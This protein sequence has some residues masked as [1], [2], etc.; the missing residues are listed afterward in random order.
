[1]E[2]WSNGVVGNDGCSIRE[3]A[4]RV[5]VRVTMVSWSCRLSCAGLSPWA[6]LWWIEPKG[7]C[8]VWA[9][10]PLNGRGPVQD[11]CA[12]DKPARQMST[13]VALRLFWVGFILRSRLLHRD[14]LQWVSSDRKMKRCEAA[15]PSYGL[16]AMRLTA[17]VPGTR[18]VHGRW[19]GELCVV[20]RVCAA[21]LIFDALRV[22][23]PKA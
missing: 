13:V 23:R 6:R 22:A 21:V 16:G 10:P 9:F 20:R 19:T 11:V 18:A 14:R 7:P 2:W 4:G 5:Y 8:V 1:L 3:P 17:N 12:S 15:P